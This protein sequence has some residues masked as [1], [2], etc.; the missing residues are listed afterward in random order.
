MEFLRNAFSL[1]RQSFEEWNQDQAPRLAA[2]LAYYIAFSLAPL[3]ILTIALVGFVLQ[4]DVVR[5]RVLGLVTSAVGPS[6]GDFV[7]ELMS[8]LRQP[9]ASFISTALGIVALLLGALGAF[10]QLKNAL[11]TV[12]GVPPEKQKLGIKGFF[13][14]KLLSFGMVLII[15]F[16]LLVS[17][18]L[19]T[20][21]SAFEAF[22]LTLGPGAEFGLRVLN[23]V[24]SNGIVILLFA[25]MFR[26]LP[27]IRLT[28]NDV[29]VGAALT[30]V[31][32][33]IGKFALGLY[34]GSSGMT[35]AYGAA[36]SFVLILL[37]I[38]Y[39]AQIVLFGAEFTHVYARRF[40]SLR[41]TSKL[42]T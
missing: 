5:D 1:L 24:L 27:D 16:L 34:L 33:A 31:L 21:M 41:E 28:W 32:F 13:L 2:A 23:L 8:S 6:A 3:L 35:S 18:I 42:T 12:W 29:A 17:L 26:F 20:A 11:N 14:N 19:S 25:M 4:E 36:G 40:G 38:Y 30:A 39:S 22:T 9:N 10:E 15:G 7:S 37:W